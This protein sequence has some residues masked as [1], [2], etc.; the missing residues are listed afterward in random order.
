MLEL[1]TQDLRGLTSSPE[2]RAEKLAQAVQD[3]VDRDRLPAGSQIGTLDELRARSGYAKAT[4]SAGVRLLRDRGVLEIRPGRGGGLYVAPS[5][6][7]VR[8]RRT[9]LSVQEE[10]TAVADAVELRESL[11]LL[12]AL[13]AARHRTDGTVATLRVLL[14]A[15]RGAADWDSFMQANW[16][17]HEEIA[18][19]CPN[20]MARAVYTAT[21]GHLGSTTSMLSGDDADMPA[22]RAARLQVH[23]DLVEAIAAGDEDAVRDAVARHDTHI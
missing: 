12:M 13:S 1:A 23:A 15:M 14:D 21:L 20:A 10:S 7:V 3:L 19:A 22:Y 9:L 11:E 17:L 16:A 4:V 18:R 6:P 2:S 8:L 5:T